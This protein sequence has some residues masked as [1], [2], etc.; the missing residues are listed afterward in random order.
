M[1][2]MKPVS[3][4]KTSLK[5]IDQGRWRLLR[6]TRGLHPLKVRRLRHGKKYDI[7]I[8]GP[9]GM[10]I[11]YLNV[12]YGGV[13]ERP[14]PGEQAENVEIFLFWAELDGMR[15]LN[16][17]TAVPEQILAVSARA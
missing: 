12:S 1:K 15:G 8:R 11:D 7:S 3:A 14:R 16:P 17:V 6:T 10:R 13:I 2:A 5:R 9:W 4:V